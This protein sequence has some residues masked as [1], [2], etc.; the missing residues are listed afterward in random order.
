M[1]FAAGL[2]T[3]MRPLTETR[4][5]PLIRVGTT[6]LLDHALDLAEEAE[7]RRIVVNIHYLGD[8]IR[9][10]V[11]QRDIAISDETGSILDT[12]GGLK[13]ALPL[14]GTDP[15]FTM[16]S[17]AVWQGP[18]PFEALRAAWDPARMGA[19]VLVVPTGA[20]MGH[21]GSGDFDVAPDGQITRGTETIYT[22]A[23]ILRTKRVR[24]MDEEVF[25]LNAIWNQFAED[26]QLF[27]VTYPG[28]WCDVGRPDC[29][30]LAETL[31]TVDV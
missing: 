1:V 2:G 12:G 7:V 4:P 30:A 18:N 28:K 23:Q 15:V 13:A 10:H 21:A 27:G 20:A 24:A 5:K 17:D 25:S 31:L 8:M 11:A 29:I 14:L 22:G 19:L 3:R 16:N 26:G 9:D 6:T